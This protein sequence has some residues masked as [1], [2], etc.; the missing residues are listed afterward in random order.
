[1]A[2]DRLRADLV[3]TVTL[4]GYVLAAPEDLHAVLKALPEHVRLTRAETGCLVFNVTQDSTNPLRFTVYE[5]FTDQAAFKAHQER[6][7]GTA[8]RAASQNM[9][10]HYDIKNA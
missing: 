8:W 4:S 3:R 2:T 5:E 9:S 10:R 6:I 1:M 7:K